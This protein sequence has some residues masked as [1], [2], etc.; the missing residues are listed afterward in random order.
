M[1]DELRNLIYT[2]KYMLI[3]LLALLLFTFI[4]WYFLDV[5]PHS[6]RRGL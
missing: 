3:I 6:D 2:K 4:M 1:K 5:N